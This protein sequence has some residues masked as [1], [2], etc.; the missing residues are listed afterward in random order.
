[1]QDRVQCVSLITM[2]LFESV[3]FLGDG[4]R[5]LRGQTG[6]R[7]HRCAGCTWGGDGSH[8]DM[9]IQNFRVFLKI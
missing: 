6:A 2:G 8:A 4:D 7:P 3:A 1:M 5:S 9:V